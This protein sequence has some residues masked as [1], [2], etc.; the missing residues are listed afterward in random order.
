MVLLSKPKRAGYNCYFNKQRA[1]LLSL[2][3][4]SCLSC[5]YVIV[6]RCAIDLSTFDPLLLVIDSDFLYGLSSCIKSSSNEDCMLLGHS[7]YEVTLLY[8]NQVS[9]AKF[10]DLSL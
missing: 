10:S 7:P 4:F 5:V 9:K 8:Q 3:L 1:I 2:A 6:E